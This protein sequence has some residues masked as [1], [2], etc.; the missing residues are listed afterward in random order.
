MFPCISLKNMHKKFKLNISVQVDFKDHY[1]FIFGDC[2]AH[3]KMQLFTRFSLGHEALWSIL[4]QS[5]GAKQPK[6]QRDWEGE[7]G[8]QENSFSSRGALPRKAD[9]FHQLFAVKMDC[10]QNVSIL[11]H[12]SNHIC[13]K[14]PFGWLTSKSQECAVELRARNVSW[15]NGMGAVG[16]VTSSL[17]F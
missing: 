9:G 5:C 3:C 17:F 10:Q 7:K 12:C 11:P 6:V 14:W 16:G 4:P 15:W 13:C 8:H 1:F 2:M